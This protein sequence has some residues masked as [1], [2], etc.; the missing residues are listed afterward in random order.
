MELAATLAWCQSEISNATNRIRAFTHQGGASLP[1]MW[2]LREISSVPKWGYN[3][4]GPEAWSPLPP[5]RWP[6]FPAS[7]MSIFEIVPKCK[8]TGQDLWASSLGPSSRNPVSLQPLLFLDSL[9]RSLLT[10]GRAWGSSL[11]ESTSRKPQV[12][13]LLGQGASTSHLRPDG[14]R[15]PLSYRFPPS[16]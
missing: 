1:R 16:V 2:P 11:R 12:C 10:G 6:P 3:C 14:C 5:P 9:V 15:R 8:R 7:T 4:G 13:A